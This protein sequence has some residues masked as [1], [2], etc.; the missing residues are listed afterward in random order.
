MSKTAAVLMAAALQVQNPPEPEPVCPW[1]GTVEVTATQRAVTVD[2]AEHPVRTRKARAA[3]HDLLVLCDAEEAMLQF[4]MWRGAEGEATSPSG[5]R[6]FAPFGIKHRRA[7]VDL[8][9][10]QVFEGEA[11][12][13][14]D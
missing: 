11:I 13:S 1:E 8:L 2:G 14:A 6:M 12:A 9:A 7:M 4:G 3:F 10:L 5:W